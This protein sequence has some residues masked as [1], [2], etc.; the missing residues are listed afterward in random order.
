MG[1]LRFSAAEIE[2][3]TKESGVFEDDQIAKRIEVDLLRT[4]QLASVPFDSETKL[5]VGQKMAKALDITDCP[6]LVKKISENVKD[7]R[8][9]VAKILL[10]NISFPSHHYWRI[11]EEIV[12]SSFDISETKAK[13]TRLLLDH[14][15]KSICK[16]NAVDGGLPEKLKKL[17]QE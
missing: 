5:L 13:L 8:N 7:L 2:R 4:A 1:F 17:A 11:F 3:K 15:E 9:E 14:Y 10:K 16:A 12:S 6:E